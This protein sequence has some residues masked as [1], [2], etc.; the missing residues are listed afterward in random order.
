MSASMPGLI[1]IAKRGMMEIL[2]LVP[3]Q[4]ETQYLEGKIRALAKRKYSGNP[5]PL[6]FLFISTFNYYGPKS[7][8]MVEIYFHLPNRNYLQQIKGISLCSNM[9]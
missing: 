8:N 1:W 3:C 7:E 6:C 4:S 2:G 5:F 9:E